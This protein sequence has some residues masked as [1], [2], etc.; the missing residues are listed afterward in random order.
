MAHIINIS[1]MGCDH[2][3]K[4]VR[5]SLEAVE[6]VAIREVSI[7]CAVVEILEDGSDS[8]WRERVSSAIDAAGYDVTD[9]SPADTTTSPN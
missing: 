7:G 5:E 2:C 8:D 6:N 4:A 3:V 1:G 9:I